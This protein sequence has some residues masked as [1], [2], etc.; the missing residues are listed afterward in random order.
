MTATKALFPLFPHP[1]QQHHP[2]PTPIN[3]PGTQRW[4]QRYVYFRNRESLLVTY[5]VSAFWHGF[6][7]GACVFTYVCVSWCHEQKQMQNGLQRSSDP[8]LTDSIHPIPQKQCRPPRK[9][10]GY[11]LFFF[12]IALVQTVQRAWQK[13]V[14]AVSITDKY[15]CIRIYTCS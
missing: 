13:K 7:P 14:T 3:T 8:L 2:T 11:Y 15:I 1:Q 12:S 4:L 5:F 10:T 9:Q 6:Y